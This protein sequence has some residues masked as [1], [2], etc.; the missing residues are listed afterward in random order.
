MLN[1]SVH[2]VTTVRY[3]YWPLAFRRLKSSVT[4]YKN[5]CKRRRWYTNTDG[6]AERRSL[7][8]LSSNKQ[9][10]FNCVHFCFTLLLI[11]NGIR[12]ARQRCCCY[13]RHVTMNLYPSPLHTWPP[14]GTTTVMWTQFAFLLN[15]NRRPAFWV[16]NFSCLFS[17]IT[18]ISIPSL[19]FHLLL[20]L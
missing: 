20:Y 12:I 19:R 1:L 7:F 10:S 4:L 8:S 9:G 2:I 3:I 14:A 5:P 6:Q 16:I 18:D 17:C 11:A 15:S 13:F